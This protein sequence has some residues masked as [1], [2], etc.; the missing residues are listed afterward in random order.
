MRNELTCLFVLFCEEQ[1]INNLLKNHRTLSDI[2]I[3]LFLSFL[4]T[5]ITKEACAFS[6]VSVHY[7]KTHSSVLWSPTQ[8]NNMQ[9]RSRLL[10]LRV[11]YL[12][13]KYGCAFRSC[14][15]AWCGRDIQ[16]EVPLRKGCLQWERGDYCFIFNLCSFWKKHFGNVEKKKK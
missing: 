10:P 4:C 5:C 15:P 14:G 12:W 16:A 11:P 8:G 1:S 13:I 2:V 3:Y 6:L 7:I 9:M